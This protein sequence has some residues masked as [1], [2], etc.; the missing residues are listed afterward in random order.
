MGSENRLGFYVSRWL[1]GDGK[2][3]LLGRI[4][5]ERSVMFSEEPCLQSVPGLTFPFGCGQVRALLETRGS[6]G[7]SMPAP[8][9][10][11]ESST[12]RSSRIRSPPM[13]VAR[14]RA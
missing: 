1:R 6:R 3:C 12:G 8:S 10:S 11:A 14:G 9:F 2:S 4:S 5:A 13:A 7:V